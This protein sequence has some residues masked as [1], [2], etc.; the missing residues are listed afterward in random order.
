MVCSRCIFYY[1]SGGF[2]MFGSLD[3]CGHVP[4]PQN[5][6]DLFDNDDDHCEYYKKRPTLWPSIMSEKE[7]KERYDKYIQIARVA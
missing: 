3:Q 5:I 2:G 4:H 1:D 6:S 7:W